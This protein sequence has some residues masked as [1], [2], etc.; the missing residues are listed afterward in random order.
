[1]GAFSLIVVINLL[2][3]SDLFFVIEMSGRNCVDRACVNCDE[4]LADEEYFKCNSCLE[5][6][7]QTECFCDVCIVSH[8]KK[9]HTIVDHNGQE[10]IICCEHKHI[11]FH[12]CSDCNVVCCTK[13]L[14]KHSLHS[15]KQSTKEKLNEIRSKVSDLLYE[16]ELNENGVSAKI[17]ESQMLVN[18]QRLEADMLVEFIDQ[19]L[20]EI[21]DTL[22][23]TLREKNESVFERKQS[24]IKKLSE[25][26]QSF[27]EDLR[28]IL[29][30][31]SSRSVNN[32]IAKECDH[33]KLKQSLGKILSFQFNSKQ[34]EYTASAYKVLLQDTEM[35][36]DALILPEVFSLSVTTPAYSP[37]T[38]IKLAKTSSPTVTF[39]H[40][41]THQGTAPRT[42]TI[43]NRQQ[44][45][46]AV[47]NSN[48]TQQTG[49]SKMTQGPLVGRDI[50]FRS[51]SPPALAREDFRRQLNR[52]RKSEVV[53]DT[54][55][56]SLPI[57]TNA[58]SQQPKTHEIK[59][60]KIDKRFSHGHKL[61]MSL[62]SV[63]L[64]KI[65]DKKLNLCIIC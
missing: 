42:V 56:T 5:T 16:L 45:V 14:Q 46:V 43:G 10:P 8:V 9:N 7:E 30:S 13:C 41:S 24:E 22:I 49:S 12:Y 34:F 18:A 37:A 58:L 19:K 59:I 62:L 55:T 35:L 38:D 11:C 40:Q 50:C 31:S 28:N 1:M 2:N 63:I 33:Q 15:F 61:Q 23:K 57:A 51:L 6:S 65:L 53:P 32:F 21:K 27:Q 60:C 26:V 64:L 4:K 54:Q 44:T 17:A 3:R 20:S 29:A 39:I 52:K 25:N 48:T 36:K 47:D